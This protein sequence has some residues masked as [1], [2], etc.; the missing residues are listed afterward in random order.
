MAILTFASLATAQVTATDA[1]EFV[2]WPF[3]PCVEVVQ[4]H[5][6]GGSDIFQESTSK[7]ERAAVRSSSLPHSPCTTPCAVGL[8]SILSFPSQQSPMLKSSIFIWSIVS[9]EAP[10]GYNTSPLP[11]MELKQVCYTSLIPGLQLRQALV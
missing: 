4:R 7:R 9:S 10:K 2:I 11:G 8:V 6:N 5:E 3:D 1:D